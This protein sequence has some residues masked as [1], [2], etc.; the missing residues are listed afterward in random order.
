[1]NIKREQEQTERTEMKTKN[2]VRPLNRP[3]GTFSPSG[4][5]AGMRGHVSS[6]FRID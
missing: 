5:K 3:A 6:I 1:M 2:L 4:E